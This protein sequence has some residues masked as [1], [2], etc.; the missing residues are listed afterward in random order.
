MISWI[1]RYF[2]HHFKTIF[3]VLLAV[4]IIS[5]IFTIGATPGIGRGERRVTE[6]MVFGYNLASQEEFGRL[7]SDS[8]LSAELQYGYSPDGSELEGYA[9]Q[10]AA[11]LQLANELHLP[12]PT[13]TE[14]ADYIKTLR[15]FMGADGQFDASRYNQFRTSLKGSGRVS[16]AYVGRVL[17]DDA[18]IDKVQKILAGPGYVLPAEVKNDLAKSDASWTIGLA[19]VDYTS[20]KPEIPVNDLALNKFFETYGSRYDV[21][22]RMVVTYAD[23]SALP[24]IGKVTVTEAEARAKYFAEPSRYPKATPD[25]KAPKATPSTP[26]DDFKAARSQVETELRVERARK[27]AQKEAADFQ[28]ALYDRKL[29]PGTADFSAFLAEQKVALKTLAP[30]TRNDGPAEL[31]GSPDIATEAF[32]LSKDHPVS[33]ALAAPAGAVVLFWKETQPAR[34]VLLGEVREKVTADYLENEKEKRFVELGRTL[35]SAIEA[36]LKAGDKFEAAVAAAAKASSVKIEAK[37]LPPFTVRQPPQGVSYDAF[38][39]LD[40]L[41]KGQVS[42]MAISKEHGY[43]LYA[44]DKK[45][46]DM[47]PANPKYAEL[48][49]QLAQGSARYNA[50]SYLSELVATEVK[51]SEPKQ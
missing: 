27:E 21:P 8:R 15:F 42:D 49:S 28:Y 10:R 4:T 47:S 2:Q 36:R 33:D 12:R 48:S 46:P 43:I 45:L 51:K 30:F 1:Q 19:T 7:V 29:V 5:F 6:R 11:S 23:F 44:A 26:D 16:E 50:N 31:G 41:T 13:S 14:V 34:H 20:F 40:R 18:R 24:L 35:H 32:N 22:P 39:G 37:M 25:P 38:S 9:F 17:A 3:A